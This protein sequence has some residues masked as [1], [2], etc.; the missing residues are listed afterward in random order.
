MNKAERLWRL[1]DGVLAWLYELRVDGR[2]IAEALPEPFM[3]ATS[4]S[5][6]EVTRDELGEAVEWLKDEG[7]VDGIGTAQGV[8]VRPRRA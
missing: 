2:T 3:A 6:S 7:Y 4:W 5:D 8:V 1:R